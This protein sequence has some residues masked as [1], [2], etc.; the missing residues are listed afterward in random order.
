MRIAHALAGAGLASLMAAASAKTPM[1]QCWEQAGNAGRP[2]VVSCLEARQ[3]ESDKDL[4]AALIEARRQARDLAKVSG[5]PL[6]VRSLERAQSR[7]VD[8]RESQCKFALAMVGSGSG[9]GD[10][11]RD[12]YIRLSEARTAE[13]RAAAGKPAAR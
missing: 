6:P 13:L 2:A 12:C 10:A 5:K 4:A 1:D 9:A 7:F 8:Y 3:R 11:Y